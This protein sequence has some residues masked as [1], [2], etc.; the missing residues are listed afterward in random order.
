[1]GKNTKMLNDEGID[2]LIQRIEDNDPGMTELDCRNIDGSRSFV[3]ESGSDAFQRMLAA[4]S[5]NTTITKV[6]LVLRFLHKLS[7]T[8]QSELFRAVGSLPNLEQLRV[9][10]S[11]LAGLPLRLINRA[12][13]KTQG[14]LK[15][16]TLHSIHFKDN[17]FYKTENSKNTNDQEYLEFL[18]ILRNRLRDGIESFSI[19]DAEDSFDLDPLVRALA[20]LP[21]L[22]DV[23]IQS[24]TFFDQRL[25]RESVEQLF[26]STSIRSLALRRLRLASILPD[27]LVGLENTTL[28]KL[29]LT[30]QGMGHECGMAL[31]YL[32]RFNENL[33]ELNVGYNMLPDECGSALAGSLA[34]NATLESLNLTANDLELHTCRRF[35]HLMA[36]NQ[37]TLEHLNLSQNSLEDE[38]VSMIGAGLMANTTLKSLSLAESRITEASCTVVAAALTSNRAL[39]RLNLADNKVRDEG[40]SALAQ[41]LQHNSTLTSLNLSR[42]HLHNK[43]VLRLSETL[44][45]NKVIEKLNLASNPDLTPEAYESL[46]ETLIHHNYTLKHLWLPTTIGIVMPNCTIPSFLRLNRLGRKELMQ[47]MDHARSWANALQASA[48]DIHTLYYLVRSNPA[49]VSWLSGPNLI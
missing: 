44:R 23:T 33:R 6:N 31:A 30:Q 40:C 17:V 49:V 21:K 19:L 9:G 24:F 5:A 37:S 20:T 3:F 39:E 27:I 36:S 32:L 38:G 14:Q 13:L 28:E 34:S 48:S 26:A 15:S 11:G 16:L 22:C 7:E 25:M 18:D 45:Q 43:G 8:E 46:Q 35:A 41:A 10:S 1:V 47:E 42:N 4:L 2:V 29:A 12:L